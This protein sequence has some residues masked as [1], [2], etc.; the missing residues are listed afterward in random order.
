M[1]E[2]KI[3]FIISVLN[4]INKKIWSHTHGNMQVSNFWFLRY[5]LITFLIT[6]NATQYHQIRI[7][8][9]HRCNTNIE[10]STKLE[11]STILGCKFRKNKTVLDLSC[12]V[13]SIGFCCKRHVSKVRFL[14]SLSSFPF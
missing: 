3:R 8:F 9:V 2:C 10:E 14:S 5:C 1:G 7:D 11:F 12:H 6:Y 13:D 4:I